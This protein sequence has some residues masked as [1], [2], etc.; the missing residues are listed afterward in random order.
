MAILFR[1]FRGAKNTLP[2]LTEGQAA[3]TIDEK[4]LYVGSASGNAVFPNELGNIASATKLQTARNINNVSFNGTSDIN[5]N[6]LIPIRLDNVTIDMDALSF[7]NGYI[8]GVWY[9]H[10]DG[11]TASISNIPEKKAFW[12]E[13]R[14]IRRNTNID[15]VQLQHIYHHTNRTCY[16][17]WNINNVYTPWVL[18]S[19]LSVTAPTA[20]GTGQTSLQGARNAMG[21][22][23][24]LDALPIA[25]GGTGGT[26][27]LTARTA[28]GITPVN[29]GAATSAQGVKADSA[30]QPT[31]VGTDLT[32]AFTQAATRVNL[33]SGEKMSIIFG[34]LMKWFADLK[35]VAFT[36]SYTDLTNTPATFAPTAHTH[37]AADITSG[38]ATLPRLPTST[39]A[40]R[41]LT[42]TTANADPAYG[43][44][45]LNS[46]VTG[47]LSILNGGTGATNKKAAIANMG[48][49]FVNDP[50]E[51]TA[52]TG[53]D[54]DIQLRPI[55]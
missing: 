22:G 24:T 37:A 20:G 28:L 42:V 33:V 3:F 52:G 14:T 12:F 2:P 21:L 39:T 45:A 48:I 27:A 13:L 54:G 7:P 1:F 44:V 47:T 10:A 38:R 29:I 35:A 6:A 34:K 51:P 8:S 25:N 26:D 31:G 4:K 23:N 40:N 16:T 19:T 41:V 43:Q 11:T 15:Y 5:I 30:L 50:D 32:A 18:S 36:G 55:Q 53:V 49:T 17:R 46:M 9:A